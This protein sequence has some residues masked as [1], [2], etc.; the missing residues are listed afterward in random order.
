MPEAAVDVGLFDAPL[1]VVRRPVLDGFP[2]G[3]VHQQVTMPARPGVDGLAAAVQLVEPGAS[4]DGDVAVASAVRHW[5]GEDLGQLEVRSASAAELLAEGEPV[6]RL[7]DLALHDPAVLDEPGCP[8]VRVDDRTRLLWTRGVR[9]RRGSVSA[10]GPSEGWVP[11]GQAVVRWLER[12]SSQPLAHTMNMAGLGAA[13]TFEAAV[14]QARADLV[15]QD[16]VTRW[17]SSG[18][19]DPLPAL[20]A[21]S[22]WDGPLELRL[23]RLPSRFDVEVVLAVVRD[24]E[25]DL[26]TLC[27]ATGPDAARRAAAGALWQLGVARDVTSPTSGLLASGMPGLLPHAPDRRYLARGVRGAVDPMSAVQLGLDPAVVAEVDRR[28]SPSR[29]AAT[30]TG[31]AP[32]EVWVVDLTTPDVAAAG[33]HCV[34]ALA[35]G[36]ARIPV[37]A[38]A[39]R[40]GLP[41]PGW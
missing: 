12:D 6:L 7:T 39:Q 22:W 10:E 18:P 41:Y 23:R 33:W 28:T 30:L 15:A 2:S 24:H 5:C 17:W 38:F 11:Y 34:R 1:R 40:Q 20:G 32:P 29:H 36:L 4:A 35:P 26:A 19:A 27:P 8:L 21:P 13:T 16:A 31:D 25:H 37:P 3:F 9:R 14:D